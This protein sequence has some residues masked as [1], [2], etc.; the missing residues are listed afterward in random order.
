MTH[1]SPRAHHCHAIDCRASCPPRFLMCPSHWRMVPL[2]LQHEVCRTVVLRAPR[3]VDATWAPWWRAAHR[4]IDHVYRAELLVR[5][6][7]DE[8]GRAQGLAWAER[9]LSKDLAFADELEAD[10]PAALA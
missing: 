1:K 7:L 4:A 10:R 9:A 8:A 5:A 6:D 3:S 2:E